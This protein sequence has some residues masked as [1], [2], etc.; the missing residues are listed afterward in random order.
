MKET[1]RRVNE[2][3]FVRFKSDPWDAIVV[4]EKAK[5]RAFSSIEG[6]RDKDSPRFVGDRRNIDHNTDTKD[7]SRGR[8]VIVVGVV[9]SYERGK[10]GGES[11]AVDHAYIYTLQ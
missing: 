8:Q 3:F 11:K 7:M 5:D 6:S 2:V 1:D 10:C 9:G 4:S